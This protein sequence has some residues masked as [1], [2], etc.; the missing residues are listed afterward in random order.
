MTLDESLATSDKLRNS[1][2]IKTSQPRAAIVEERM[3][4]ER[5]WWLESGKDREHR[6]TVEGFSEHEGLVHGP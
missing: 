3:G 2:P 5:T 4:E 6:T 1:S